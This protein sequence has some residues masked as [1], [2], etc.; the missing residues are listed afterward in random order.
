MRLPLLPALLLCL[1][2]TARLPAATVPQYDHALAQVQASLA[3]RIPA[4]E[5]HEIPS[6]PPPPFVARRVLLPIRSVGPPG[7]PAQP[8]RNG[9]LLQALTD[10]DR[11]RDIP[12][13]KALE[14]QI[15]TLRASLSPSGSPRI[16][17]GGAPDPVQTAHAILDRP[18]YG[19]DPFPPPP[20]SER[21]AHWLD[22]QLQKIQWPHAPNTPNINAPTVSPGFI[23]GLL[24]L[25]AAGA[26]AVLVAVLVQALSRRQARARSIPLLDE[27][28][29]ALVEARDTGSLFALAERQAQGGDYRR[30]FRLVY[31][32]TLVALDTGGVLRFDRSKTNWEYLRAL[33]AAGRDDVYQ[34]MMPLT[35]DFDRLW[36]GLA[37]AGLSEYSRAVAQYQALQ[38]APLAVSPTPIAS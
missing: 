5:A 18:E 12:K 35:R 30:A 27:A 2:L 9:L 3:D 26:V 6:G 17:G 28:E 20:L 29:A 1:L 22:Q 24:I 32:A 21:I 7:G 25:L 15:A 4:L 23:K 19:S 36:Y 8:V 11:K 10:A 31:I 16:G 14:Q 33:R 13:M 34:A 38:A 37:P